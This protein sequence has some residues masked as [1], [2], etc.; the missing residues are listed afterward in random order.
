[1]NFARRSA[2]A[3][4]A[5]VFLLG[6]AAGQ[7]A[8][9]SYERQFRE[10]PGAVP[11]PQFWLGTDELGRD[12]FSRLIYGAR[13]S[14]LLAP[15]AALLATF[16]AAL[17]GVVAG[18]FGGLPQRAIL[19]LCDLFLSLPWL[20][21]LL[22]AR[23]L[24]PLN[25]GSWAS[26]AVTFSLLGLLG[27]ASGARVI[28]ST[29]Q[30]LRAS[31]FAVQALASGCSRRRLLLIQIVPNLRPVLVAQFWISLPLFIVAEA[32]LGVLGLGVAE[33]LPSL[34]NLLSELQNYHALRT[35]PWL[36]A[37][38]LLL[39]LVM[40]SLQLVLDREDVPA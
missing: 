12:R 16:L 2:A 7:V 30:S 6:L 39:V 4:L 35:S 40:V 38:A 9:Y 32:N 23:A 10:H 15:A 18:W 20:F 24:L 13:V 27:W 34:G 22:T 25:V 31:D 19:M 37:P 28:R 3:I 8:P 33:P 5:V 29:V 17:A 26:V 14:L 21:L 1:M 36:L 11:G